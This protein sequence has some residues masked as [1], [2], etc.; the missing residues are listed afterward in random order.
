MR[1]DYFDVIINMRRNEVVLET[2]DYLHDNATIQKKFDD[3]Y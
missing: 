1:R 3:L 2:D